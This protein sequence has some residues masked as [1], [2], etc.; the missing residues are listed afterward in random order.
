MKTLDESASFSN[1][2][3]RKRQ[4]LQLLKIVEHLYKF[5]EN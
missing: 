5:I 2:T 4:Q 1:L 3:I